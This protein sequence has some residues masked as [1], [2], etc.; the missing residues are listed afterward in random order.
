MTAEEK[1]RNN[2]VMSLL[3]IG[4]TMP[5]HIDNKKFIDETGKL[6]IEEYNEHFNELDAELKEA[7]ELLKQWSKANELGS[8]RSKTLIDTD[9][10]LNKQDKD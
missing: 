1:K 2:F 5:S 9:N 3:A 7:R 4:G 10:F 8:Y 6:A